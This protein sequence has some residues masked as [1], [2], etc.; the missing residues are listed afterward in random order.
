MYCVRLRRWARHQ[1][2]AKY[3]CVAMTQ[4]PASTYTLRRADCSTHPFR[5]SRLGA[6]YLLQSAHEIWP[7]RP[8]SPFVRI[9]L[10]KT[11]FPP[12]SG[13]SFNTRLPEII[14]RYQRC[15]YVSVL[16]ARLPT[17]LSR[18]S[19]GLISSLQEISNLIRPVRVVSKYVF[20]LYL[21][22]R[23]YTFFVIF[24][25]VAS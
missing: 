1:Q 20:R 10:L 15:R 11:K 12:I 24:S 2:P 6:S 19:P 25:E 8:Y 14:I 7:M 13:I 21:K 5:M 16:T 22:H 17:F 4:Q 23:C 9:F 3:P 18:S